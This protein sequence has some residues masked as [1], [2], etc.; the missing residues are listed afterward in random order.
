MKVAALI[1]SI[2]LAAD[3]VLVWA[4]CKSAGDEDERAG[5]K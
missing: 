3:I 1:I 4:L 2:C 5:R